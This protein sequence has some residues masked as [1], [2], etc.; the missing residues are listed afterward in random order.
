MVWTNILVPVLGGDKDAQIL[1]IAKALAEPF[2]AAITAVYGSPSAVSLFNW[3][4]EGSFG[5]TDIAIATLQKSTERGQARCRELLADIGYAKTRFL[6]VT[7][8]DWTGLRFAT[9]LAD[10]VIW[11]RSVTRGHGFFASAFQQIL[12][13]ER[14]PAFIA[15]KPLSP[16][17][18]VGIAWDGG[19]EASRA[20][21]R[22][23]PLLRDAARII[24]FSV[25]HAMAHPCDG[26]LAIDYLAD[27]GIKAEAKILHTTGDAGPAILDAIREV[28]VDLLVAGAFGHPRLQRFIFGGTTQY[29]LE[30]QSGAALFLSH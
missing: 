7:A 21:R 15:D 3:G 19:R 17:G 13:D 12:L 26:S 1:T 29:L 30:N 28:G 24:I 14:R 6:A 23:V 4:G 2:D 9:R 18:T 16:G 20:L 27:R 22:A 5:P 11:E 10:V 8:D 25:P